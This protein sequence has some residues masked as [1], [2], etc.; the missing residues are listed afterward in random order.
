[1]NKYLVGTTFNIPMSSDEVPV[2]SLQSVDWGLRRVAPE[3]TDGTTS[4]IGT[5][6]AVD[7]PTGAITLPS[8]AV[9]TRSVWLLT[10]T[11]TNTMSVSHSYETSFIIEA[12]ETLVKG[13]NSFQSYFE[14]MLSAEE[15]S[16]IEFFKAAT[17]EEQI[18][19]LVSAYEILSTM[20]YADRVGDHYNIGNYTA[21]ELEALEPAFLRA[22]RIA[23]ILE[24]N[25]MLDAHSI[26]YKRQDGLMSETIGESS[27]MFRP[28]NIQN[29]PITR[30]SLNFLRNYVVIRARL[31]RA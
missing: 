28:G 17:K 8:D 15:V 20:V 3:D 13:D 16:G 21:T 2:G 10:Y 18:A 19:A 1:M 30:R 12:R 29:F 22:L 24:A 11:L 27:M 25:E 5:F 9:G 23:Q 31:Y 4:T 7:N 6:L 26:H 14:T